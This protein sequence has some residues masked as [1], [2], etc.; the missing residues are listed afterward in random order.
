MKESEKFL[1]THTDKHVTFHYVNNSGI[2]SKP[3]IEVEKAE[4]YGK[5]CRLEGE[6]DALEKYYLCPSAIKQRENE[7]KKLMK[8]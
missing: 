2:Y 6:I 4:I 1:E 3:G 5:I 8:P 7:I